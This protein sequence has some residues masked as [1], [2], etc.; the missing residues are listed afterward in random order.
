MSN[1]LDRALLLFQQAR[2]E[3]AA[4][5]LEQAIAANASDATAHALLGLCLARS[6]RYPEALQAAQQALHL[7]PDHAYCHYALASVLY[8]HDRLAEAQTAISEAIRLDPHEVSYFALQAWIEI[9]QQHWAEA[10]TSAEQGLRLNPEHVGCTNLRAMALVKLGRVPEAKTAVEA[11]LAHSPDDALSHANLGWVLLEQASPH[12]ALM[13]FREAL[14]LNPELEW[15]RQGVVEAL[16]ARNPIYGLMLRYFLWLPKLS[17]QVR[18][19]IFLGLFVALRA[20][21]NLARANPELLSWFWPVLTVYG[22]FVLM[23]WLADPLFTLLLRLDRYGRLTL[24]SQEVTASNWVGGSLLLALLAG[25]VGLLSRSSSAWLA[26]AVFALLLLPLA[27]TFRCSPG[28]PHRVMSFY[29]GTLAVIG[30]AAVGL[31]L[32]PGAGAVGAVNRLLLGLFGIG[33]LLSLWVAN[34]LVMLRPKS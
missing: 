34:L 10:L 4:E 26:A 2:Y 32:V 22:L 33:V 17:W 24:S 7:A 1:S 27:A 25:A 21:R 5:A 13:S 28:W 16:K 19:G 12:Q 8:D 14:R 3:L 31:S 29:T 6:K 23:S 11:A 18:W 20:L 15:A 30:L 9:D